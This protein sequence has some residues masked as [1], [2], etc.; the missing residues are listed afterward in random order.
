MQTFPM[1]GDLSDWSAIDRLDY[2]GTGVAGYR[3][4]GRT[5]LADGKVYF[6]FQTD[7]TVIGANTTVWLD[8]DLDPRTG[9]QIWGAF[10]GAEFNVNFNADKDGVVRPYLY[11]GAAGET[12]ISPKPLNHAF[13]GTRS[14]V[15][16]VILLKL[17]GVD[18][19]TNPTGAMN[20]L[21]DVNDTVFLPTDYSTF[22]YSVID[23]TTLPRSPLGRHRI[24]LISSP[25]TAAN[26]F[27]AAAY[28]ELL[29][30]VRDAADARGV[31]ITVLDEHDLRNV[32]D[33]VPFGTLIFPSF[34]NVPLAEHEAVQTTLQTLAY[35][36]GTGFVAG[37]NFMTNDEHGRPLPGDPYA[38]MKSLLNVMRTG[39]SSLVDVALYAADTAHPMMSKLGPGTLISS[40][41]AIGTQTFVGIDTNFDQIE[42][43]ATQVVAGEASNGVIATWTG[44]PNIFFCVEA[45][46]AAE[47]LVGRLFDLV[48]APARRPVPARAPPFAAHVDHVLPSMQELRLRN[49]H[50]HIFVG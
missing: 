31:P 34:Q 42:T 44:G 21:A 19:R 22:T 5:D 2:A 10:G 28:A 36:Y 43:I 25:T 6:A 40:Y 49:G 14:A 13:N 27:D 18:A 26:Y 24:A 38:R 8:T 48:G 33:L 11:S 50:S 7:G 23:P 20:V 37:G 29:Q 32:A 15:E 45:F 39:G 16:F 1:N 47:P 46:L 3:L 9:H 35:R 4:Y 30:S 17:L 41:H 12:L